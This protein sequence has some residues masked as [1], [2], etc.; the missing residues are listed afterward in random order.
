MS[1]PVLSYFLY[2]FERFNARPCYSRPNAKSLWAF[3]S[4]AAPVVAATVLITQA[5]C[6]EWICAAG[7]LYRRCGSCR[8]G[9]RARETSVRI[10][11][12]AVFAFFQESSWISYSLAGY[13][14]TPIGDDIWRQWHQH[15]HCSVVAS[16]DFLQGQTR[17]RYIFILSIQYVQCTPFIT[18]ASDW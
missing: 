1:Q 12:I 8:S 10:V 18:A 2:T 15:T 9:V 5:S 3:R 14:M 16:D 7:L 11:Q 4:V 17:K 13:W 6:L